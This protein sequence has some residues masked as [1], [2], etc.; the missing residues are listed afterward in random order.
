MSRY[1]MTWCAVSMKAAHLFDLLDGVL[2]ESVF[3]T[4]RHH[5]KFPIRMVIATSQRFRVLPGPISIASWRETSRNRFSRIIQAGARAEVRGAR[6]RRP[7][8]TVQNLMLARV[9]AGIE[10]V[11]NPVA[12]KFTSR[13]WSKVEA[14]IPLFGKG[15]LEWPALSG[16]PQSW[17]VIHA[18]MK[19]SFLCFRKFW[20]WFVLGS[21]HLGELLFYRA[22]S[23]N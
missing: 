1:L 20:Y 17:R 13:P 12:T 11:R 22:S 10:E 21:W 2:R 14:P 18:G 7:V 19:S 9:N 8:T 5:A 16:R 3:I 23:K 4:L 15:T 6:T